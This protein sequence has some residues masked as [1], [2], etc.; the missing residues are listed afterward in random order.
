M[1][2]VETS[3]PFEH[4]SATPREGRPPLKGWVTKKKT[5]GSRSKFISSVNRRFFT[6]DF[7][8]QVLY[9]GHTE[10]NKQ[11]SAPIPF[12]E[13]LRVEALEE[14]VGQAEDSQKLSRADS[15]TSVNSKS[16]GTLLQR[17]P[18]LLSTKRPQEHFGVKLETTAKTMEL[19]F[20]SKADCDLW[21][22]AFAEAIEMGVQAGGPVDGSHRPISTGSGTTASTPVPSFRAEA[23]QL[24]ASKEEAPAVGLGGV[25]L[26]TPHS[27]HQSPGGVEGEGEAPPLGLHTPPVTPTPAQAPAAPVEDE[28]PRPSLGTPLASSSQTPPLILPEEET[29]DAKDSQPGEPIPTSWGGEEVTEPL[30]PTDAQEPEPAIGPDEEPAAEEEEAAEEA[31]SS[32]KIAPD[33]EAW[34]LGADRSNPRGTN[35]RYSDKG[36]GLSIQQRLAQLEFSDDEEDE[37]D[38]S[39]PTR[40]ARLRSARGK[41]ERAEKHQAA[42]EK[43]QIDEAPVEETVVEQCQAFSADVDSDDD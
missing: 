34:S 8:T 14:P 42:L 35:V 22:A 31:T 40:A 6:I 12:R 25:G 36:E 11:L 24:D 15:K 21:Q 16:S 39:D 23:I 20:A 18:S 13:L 38:A 1:A 10:C 29:A 27:V 17:M 41:K 32:S 26:A 28:A 9:Y 19:F 37:E 2:D 5:E 7:E 3:Q 33:Q 43:A 30:T 4:P